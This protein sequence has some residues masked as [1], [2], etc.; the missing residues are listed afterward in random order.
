[1]RFQNL[2][3][4]VTPKVSR[5]EAIQKIQPPKSLSEVTSFL[6]SIQYLMRYIPNLTTKTEPLRALLQKRTKWN[7]TETE[8]TAFENLKSEIQTI[9]PLKDY[10]AAET[11]ILTTDA[12]TKG[13]G[14]TLWQNGVVGKDSKGEPK[15]SRGS[16]A[17]ASRFLHNSERNYAPN[18]LELLAVVWDVYYFKQYLLD[19][20]LRLETDHK[21]LVSVFNR[22]RR[23]KGDSPRLIPYD[24]EVFYRQGETMGITD[25]LAGSPNDSEKGE[26][27]NGMLTI[28]LIKDL[29]NMKNRQIKARVL[30]KLLKHR[31]KVIKNRNKTFAT[32]KSETKKSDN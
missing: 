3:R 23:N 1:M 12:S 30:S 31:K 11:A 21:A 2:R 29:N 26:E 18:E 13:L 4:G 15:M 8:N 5:V 16:V 22:E 19:R 17:F 10:D 27:D 32:K 7:W 9:V 14:A 6:G 24:F 25:Y 20:K 28:M